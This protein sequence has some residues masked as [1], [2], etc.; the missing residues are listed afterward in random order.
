M[1]TKIKV[2][3]CVI[4]AE[5]IYNYFNLLS[6]NYRTD[7]PADFHVKISPEDIE[8]GKESFKAHNTTEVPADKKIEVFALH[9]KVCELLLERD[10]FFMHGAAIAVNGEGFVF[11]AK[12][13]TG[14]TTHILKWLRQCPDAI[15]VNG[16]K[17]FISVS[18]L[19]MVCG[20]PW[21]G[22]EEM[23]TNT[24]VPLKAIIMLQRSEDNRFE[25]ISPIEA[26]P[27]L[28]ESVY[29]PDDEGKQKKTLALIQRLNPTV[30][31]W[32]FYC[33]NFKEDC[34][35]IAYKALVEDHK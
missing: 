16:D 26:F 34:F 28:L 19:P 17:P 3:G 24:I 25:K 6:D 1:T 5:C 12:S 9:K 13:G 18:G 14:K 30:Q 10:V 11:T 22:K 35:D 7:E 2:A 33:N 29:F 4:E 31:Y 23:Q 27:R 32:R 20:T 15:V 21:A 8:E